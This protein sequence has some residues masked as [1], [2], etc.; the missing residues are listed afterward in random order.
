MYKE[1]IYQLVSHGK[2]DYAVKTLLEWSKQLNDA[3]AK[4][5]VMVLS[6][7]WNNFNHSRISGLL[8]NFEENLTRN[9]IA[10]SLLEMT[11]E[12]F[13]LVSESAPQHQNPNQN[14]PPQ[15]KNIIMLMA[16]PAKTASLKLRDEYYMIQQSV[17]H[18]KDKFAV[19]SDEQVTPADILKA[20]THPDRLPWC[21][22]FSGHGKYG[23]PKIR[24]ML[25]DAKQNNPEGKTTLEDGSGL[26]V[27]SEDKRSY[28]IMPTRALDAIFK[29]LKR[30]VPSLELVV[31]NAC[32]SEVQANVIS[33][34]GFY[35]VGAKDKIADTASRAFSDV[36]YDTLAKG[37]D[38]KKAVEFG[39]LNA[40]MYDLKHENDI[41]LF[42]N[43]EKLNI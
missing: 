10:H 39:R 9:R 19:Y 22:H 11:D 7:Q 3:Q 4:N 28:K 38:L 36:F 17:Q 24:K 12:F 26:I 27:A 29:S 5:G 8:S 43:G 35:V 15:L 20:A 37:S 25:E 13:N 33:Q 32:Y 21:L 34:H 16:N 30:N 42:Y 14:S 6:A 41:N 40:L 18:H 31:L 1:K 2:L 23:D